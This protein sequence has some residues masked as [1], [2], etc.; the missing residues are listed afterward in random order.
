MPPS[1]PD[2]A[3]CRDGYPP[4]ALPP[5]ALHHSW[6]NGLS[7]G[8]PPITRGAAA[9]PWGAGARHHLYRLSRAHR[10]VS[11][12]TRRARSAGA[13]LHCPGPCPEVD[14]ADRKLTVCAQKTGAAGAPWP[15]CRGSRDWAAQLTWLD[16]SE[17]HRRG[18]RSR[19]ALCASRCCLIVAPRQAR[20]SGRKQ[21]RLSLVLAGVSTAWNLT[22]ALQASDLRFCVARGGV[23]PPTFRFSGV[24]VT[25]DQQRCDGP[26]ASVRAT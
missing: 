23:E 4:A 8:G 22:E 11:Q 12:W 9:A 17:P 1:P 26:R 16:V 21:R 3:A 24:R 20:Q 13:Q 5:G 15:R 10:D 18:Y 19:C 6:D 25:A 14:V 2:A 7:W